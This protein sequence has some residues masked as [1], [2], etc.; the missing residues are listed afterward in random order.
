MQGHKTSVDASYLRKLNSRLILDAVYARETTS[1]AALSKALHLSKPAISDNLADLLQLG[2]IVEIGEG[3]ATKKGGRRPLLL[4]FNKAYRFI[5]ALDLSYSNPVAV[6]GNL[7]NEIIAE[8]D[9][10]ISGDSS[11]NQYVESITKGI[12]HLLRQGNCGIKDV[13]C[14]AISSPGVFDAEGNI[15]SQNPGYSRVML[16]ESRLLEALSKKYGINLMIKNDIKAATLGEWAYGAGQGEE[17]L[18]YV[19]CG[20]GLGTGF[21]LNGELFEGK[22]FNAGEIYYYLDSQRMTNAQ[23]LEDRVCMK[24]LIESCM[25]DIR[26]G[27]ETCLGD[28]K[29]RIGFQD[30]VTAYKNQDPYILRK[31]ERISQELCILMFNLGNFLGMDTVIFGG[32][33]A[34][35]GETLAAVYQTDLQ[36]RLRAGASLR[37][38][39][40]GK[41]SSTHGML[42]SA[43]DALFSTIC[44]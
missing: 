15:L 12:D 14:I 23:P 18:L 42:V 8:T 32:E 1:R 29:G 22:R 36:P 5:V 6:L 20:V 43:R 24:Q 41:Y 10:R 25:D 44:N 34:V 17:H 27:A 33:Y 30:I 39:K 3:A 21:V 19:S 16:N 35:F 4:K 11:K 7:Q 28:G 9:I 31:I 37:L 40:L 26:A 2:V 13:F 38:A